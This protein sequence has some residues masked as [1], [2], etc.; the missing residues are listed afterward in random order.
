MVQTIAPHSPFKFLDSYGQ[1]DRAIFFGRE[2]EIDALYELVMSSQLTL[3]YGASGTGKTSLIECGL[4]N[5]FSETDWFAIRI[6][7]GDDITESTFQA[8]RDRTYPDKVIADTEGSIFNAVQALYI[9]YYI[10]IYLIFDQFE[11]LFISGTHAE[12][13]KFFL[14]LKKVLESG[15]PCKVILVM[16]EEYIAYL[17]SYEHL[18]P[19]LFNSKTKYRIEKMNQLKL[20]TVVMGTIQAPQYNIIFEEPEKNTN[21]I[22]ENLRNE[23]REVDLTNLQVYLDRLYSEDLKRKEQNNETRPVTFDTALIEEKVG[24]LPQVLSDFLEEQMTIVDKILDSPNISLTLLSAFVTNEGTKQSC[25]LSELVD[26]LKIEKNIPPSVS[27]ACIQKFYE[28][29]ILRELK[30]GDDLQYEITHDLLARQIHN[31]FSAEEKDLRKA[32]SRI[33]DAYD[34]H[35]ELSKN[36]EGISFMTEEQLAYL[37]NIL[38]KLSLSETLLSYFEDSKDAVTQEK[39]KEKLMLQKEVALQKQQ[40]EQEQ[41]A[42]ALQQA[43]MEQERREHIRNQEEARKAREQAD[44]DLKHHKRRS[45]VSLIVGL[46]MFGLAVGAIYGFSRIKVEKKNVEREKKNVEKQKDD[47]E[48]L[49]KNSEKLNA[50]LVEAIEA[51]KKRKEELYKAFIKNG[52]T[53]ASPTVKQY[54]E[55]IVEYKGAIS[56]DNRDSLKITALIQECRMKNEKLIAQDN[57]QKHFKDLI[58][59]GS[60]ILDAE[61][62]KHNQLLPSKEYLDAKTIFNEAEL[63]IIKMDD[64]K[65]RREMSERFAEKKE[66]LTNRMNRAFNVY[67][68][69]AERFKKVGG[70]SEALSNYQQALLLKPADAATLKAIKDCENLKNN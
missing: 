46:A 56:I 22:I 37:Q 61:T 4:S 2:E 33:Q 60:T 62:T 3:V 8:I 59:Q 36:G 48:I 23:R 55:A 13:E 70:K 42:Q 30:M 31:R 34:F 65:T 29:R 28:K 41:K 51:A 7:K 18:I 47:N 24:K 9:F 12:Q 39:E 1:E 50:E 15:K 66:E 63:L 38:P 53:K 52:D 21:T 58:R 44:L 11:E 67:T 69:K 54:L 17:S 20:Q 5:R 14:Q 40:L 68:D 27:H 45:L 49:L 25:H 35:A 43:L 16:R 32:T 10:P 26:K 57:L 6:R 19:S 64:E